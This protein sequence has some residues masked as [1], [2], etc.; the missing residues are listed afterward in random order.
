MLGELD[1]V[2]TACRRGHRDT[3]SGRTGADHRGGRRSQRRV[4]RGALGHR[5]HRIGAYH[6]FYGDP[7]DTEAS[8][9]VWQK[10]LTDLFPAPVPASTSV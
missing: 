10:W 3:G 1:F 5:L 9:A 8:T 4:P 6:Y 7:V 2:R